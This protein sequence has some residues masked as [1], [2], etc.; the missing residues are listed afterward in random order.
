MKITFNQKRSLLIICSIIIIIIGIYVAIVH[1]LIYQ[2]AIES[3]PDNV[4][5]VIVLGARIHG[6]RMSLALRYRVETALKYLENNPDSKLVL[7]GGKG[8]GEDI[9]EAEAMARF[10]L[11]KGIVKDRIILEDQ[12]TTTNE[13]LS[14]SKRFIED[15]K[16]VLIVSND[17]HLFRAKLI[18]ERLGYKNI[19]TLAAKTPFVVETKLWVRE[20]AAVLKTWVFDR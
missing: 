10:F 13:N 12:S 17:F 19:H 1:H 6:E 11:G 15:E 5:Y 18:A 4:E 8:N 14:F 9:T 3:P 2:T 7:S 20:Y 16:S